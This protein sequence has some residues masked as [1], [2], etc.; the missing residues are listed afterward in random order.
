MKN[1]K[2]LKDRA[3]QLKD[4]KFAEVNPIPVTLQNSSAEP[5]LLASLKYFDTKFYED[6]LYE[7]ADFLRGHI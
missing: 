5:G 4:Y 6:E 2:Y 3:A 1:Q 7:F